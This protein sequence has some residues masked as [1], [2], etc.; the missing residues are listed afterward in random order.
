LVSCGL[1]AP[2]AILAREIVGNA[3]QSLALYP[4]PSARTP[5]SVATIHTWLLAREQIVAATFIA[6]YTETVVA[7]NLASM[8]TLSQ[9]VTTLASVTGVPQATVFAYGRFAREA[10]LISQGGR[11]RGGAQMTATDAA[12]LLIAVGGTRITRD[13][14]KAIE[15]FRQLSGRVTRADSTTSELT[16][17]L[18]Q[19]QV[20]AASR[21]YD[22]E[23]KLGGFVEFLIA[24]A[25]TGGLE[26]LLRSLKIFDMPDISKGEKLEETARDSQNLPFKENNDIDI[27]RDIRVELVFLPARGL[28]LFNVSYNR[29]Y[30]GYR[31]YVEF[32]Q[33]DSFWLGDLHWFSSFSQRT[34]LALGHCL[35]VG[36]PETLSILSKEGQ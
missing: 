32:G 12:N 14:N 23:L 6:C 30:G 9:L 24:E 11:G 35:K 2:S 19:Y 22:P 26:N 16:N 31:F 27:F 5:V 20:F 7:T 8:A 18:A 28:I 10:G 1:E 15:E 29:R 21:R 13:A 34:I 17:W 33:R 3:Q 25:S 4:V 36:G